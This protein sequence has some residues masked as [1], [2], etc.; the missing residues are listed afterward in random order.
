MKY[1][2]FDKI[3]GQRRLV[4]EIYFQW[5]KVQLVP[6]EEKCHLKWIRIFPQ[7]VFERFIERFDCNSEEIYVGDI[8]RYIPTGDEFFISEN[9]Q[10]YNNTVGV[11]DYLHRVESKDL[12]VI[13]QKKYDTI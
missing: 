2:A 9:L 8:L 1:R 5:E 10:L 7:I 6:P 13:G 12:E 4:R 11:L 3:T